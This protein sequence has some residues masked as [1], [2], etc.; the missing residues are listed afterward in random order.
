[1][2]RRAWPEIMEELA[3]IK[4]ITWLNVNVDAKPRSSTE[5]SSFLPSPRLAMQLLSSAG[6]T[7]TTLNRR[8]TRSLD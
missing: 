3:K 1:M 7:W 5:T 6:R 8:S 2:I 4:R